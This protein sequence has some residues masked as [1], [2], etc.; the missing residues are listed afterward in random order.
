MKI[1]RRATLA[2]FKPDTWEAFARG[3][4]MAAPFTRR[5]VRTLAEAMAKQ[6][7]IVA[8]ALAGEGLDQAAPQSYAA[9]VRERAERCDG[10]RGL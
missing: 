5:R 3:V 7:P 6:A 8:A 9:I 4:G 10:S 2:E 1:A